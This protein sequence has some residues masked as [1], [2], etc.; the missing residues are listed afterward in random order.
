MTRINHEKD[1]DDDDD[2]DDD[3]MKDG[4]AVVDP[5][6]PKIVFVV[7]YRD[8]EHQRAFFSRHMKYILEDEPPG[9]CLILFAEQCFP[10]SFNRG[11]IKNAGFMAVKARWPREYKDMTVVFNDLDVMPYT[12]N[13]FQYETTPGTVKHFFGYTHVLGGLVS[14]NG[15]DFERVNGF[16]HFYSY[17]YEDSILQRRVLDAGLQIDRNNFYA[18]RSPHAVNV[19]ALNDGI[20]RTGNF[21][22]HQR[23]LSG[24]LVTEGLR[25]VRRFQYEFVDDA[26]TV[27]VH[28]FDFGRPEIVADN[29]TVDLLRGQD[30]YRHLRDKKNMMNTQTGDSRRCRKIPSILFR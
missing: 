21:P 9:K 23:Y 24:E 10:G 14:I 25:S 15:G 16:P 7:P 11:G 2:D 30:I 5:V 26:H 12:K 4:D 6:V 22:E 17:G 8:R 3:K 29:I 1:D 19:M 18:A 27:K 20:E 13:F 28:V